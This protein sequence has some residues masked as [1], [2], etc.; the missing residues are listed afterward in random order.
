MEDAARTVK[1]EMTQTLPRDGRSDACLI[2]KVEVC[3]ICKARR[4][5]FQ[6]AVCHHAQLAERRDIAL[7]TDMLEHLVAPVMLNVEVHEVAQFSETVQEIWRKRRQVAAVPER[8]G[9]CSKRGK[10]SPQGH[11]VSKHKVP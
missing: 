2:V 9:S 1:A 5:G 7:E 3:K 6:G 10:A 11:L 8:L 4:T